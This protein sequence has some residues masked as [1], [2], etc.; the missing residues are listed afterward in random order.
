M[1]AVFDTYELK[2]CGGEFVYEDDYEDDWE[3]AVIP[4]FIS[5][6]ERNLEREKKLLEERQKVE[7]ADNNITE[8]LFSGKKTEYNIDEINKHVIL[9]KKEKPNGLENR[10]EKL[11]AMQKQ[12]SE[13][14]KKRKMEQKR[15][16]EIY[17]EAELD[18]YDELYGDIQD[19]Y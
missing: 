13:L 3:N 8:E 2:K 1:D 10:R 18:E 19:K 15:L 11:I 7:E 6:R 5:E 14:I 12:K 17:G 16:K 4:D 9:A